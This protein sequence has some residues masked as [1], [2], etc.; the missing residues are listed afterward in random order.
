RHSRLVQRTLAGCKRCFSHPVKR[1]Q[2]LSHNNLHTAFLHYHTSADHD[3]ILFLAQ[4]Y[5]GFKTL[6]HLG[7]LVWPDAPH[8]QSYNIVPM[9]HTVDVEDNC[10]S[11]ILPVSKTD[12]FG[13]GS[14]VLVQCTSYEDNCMEIFLNYLMSRDTVFPHH[15]ELWLRANSL[16]LTCS[17]FTTHFQHI[18]ANCGFS[19]HSIQAGGA[20]AL[21]LVGVSP[22][23][24]Q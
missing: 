15:L 5:F 10:V 2:P 24:I 21:V 23:I 3:D 11:Y 6:Q 4:L 9:C 22:D 8:I 7:E 1:K 12:K 19:G 13:H 17:W 18:F 16:I 20:T 14:Q